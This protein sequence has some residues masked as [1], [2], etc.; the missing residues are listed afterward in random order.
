M[1]YSELDCGLEF[2]MTI[3]LIKSVEAM[4]PLV[5]KFRVDYNPKAAGAAF[6][7]PFILYSHVC[8]M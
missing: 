3:E 1:L 7:L 5:R 4:H 6:S 8:Q 2:S